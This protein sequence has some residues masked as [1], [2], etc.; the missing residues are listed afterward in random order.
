M[1]KN[2]IELTIYILTTLCV[3]L[4][5]M[6]G[7]HTLGLP[8]PRTIANHNKCSKIVWPKEVTTIC[9]TKFYSLGLVSLLNLD[10]F[11]YRSL[12]IGL[13]DH[14]AI[15]NVPKCKSLKSIFFNFSM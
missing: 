3:H 12:A 6:N 9:P 1:K 8:S 10:P 4:S 2:W 14:M 7:G 11:N 13:L 15:S 5:S